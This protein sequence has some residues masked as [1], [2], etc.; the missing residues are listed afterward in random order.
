MIRVR[1]DTWTFCLFSYRRVKYIYIYT[2]ELYT[3]IY[4]G[5]LYVYKPVI[6]GMCA[7]KIATVDSL[8]VGNIICVL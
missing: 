7:K 1:N 5:C 2:R 4:I 3:Y 6:G 8:Y